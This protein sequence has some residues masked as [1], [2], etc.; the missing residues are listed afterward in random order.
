MVL[1]LLIAGARRCCVK[2][3]AHFYCKM[4]VN[5]LGN[6]CPRGAGGGAALWQRRVGS[7]ESK[8]S[9]G[10]VRRL[11]RPTPLPERLG[12]WVWWWNALNSSWQI[13]SDCIDRWRPPRIVLRAACPLVAVSHSEDEYRMLRKQFNVQGKLRCSGNRCRLGASRFG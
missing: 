9:P 2:E 12:R 6:S 11:T 4:L 1:F 5:L 13:W 8:V 7:L 10:L 3:K